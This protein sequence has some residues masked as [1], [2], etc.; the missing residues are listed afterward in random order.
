MRFAIVFVATYIFA[1]PVAAHTFGEQFT[2]PLPVNYYVYGGMFA[3]LFS[4][5]VLLFQRTRRAEWVVAYQLSDST[6]NIGS[7]ILGIAGAGLTLI[8][9]TIAFV[10]EQ[11]YTDNPVP[12]I[13]WIMFLL[14]FVYVSAIFGGLWN[15]IDPF[16]RI[17]SLFSGARVCQTPTWLYF[18]P[19]LTY[20]ALLWLELLSPGWGGKPW[21]V[22]TLFYAYAVFVIAMTRFFGSRA[23]FSTG[24]FFA[25][26]FDTVSRC[27]SVYVSKDGIKL[28][29]PGTRL[30]D[31]TPASVG[32]ILF[33]CVMLGST[34]FDSIKET[35]LWLSW[36]ISLNLNEVTVAYY[37]E[38]TTLL[39]LPL[40]ILALYMLTIA[41]MRIVTRSE[42]TLRE[43][44]LR[45]G[46]S[47]VPIA[48]T[49]HFAHYFS[50]ILSQG[51][52]LFVQ[53]SDPLTKGWNIFGTAFYQYNS[54]LIGSDKVWYMQLGAIV[55][56]HI[57]AALVSHGI[58]QRVFPSRREVILAQ[59]PMMTLMTFYTAFGI[60]TLAQPFATG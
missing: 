59:L 16:R 26:L 49:Y 39:I 34:L 42:S 14:A 60:W 36:I 6:R 40:L 41:L 13:F 35:G 19:A 47:L 11:N 31:S 18:V 46:Y 1:L 51:Q 54:E 22:G 4:C 57:L 20:Y 17:A 58:A 27:A 37:A 38:V 15:Y 48:I 29:F 30:I 5:I 52:Y 56:G 8:V 12:N 43:L 24:D 23:W 21:V 2:L 25:T 28:S 9:V 53:I 3:F 33:I 45:F 10:G 32:T 50:I 44:A 55:L 7:K